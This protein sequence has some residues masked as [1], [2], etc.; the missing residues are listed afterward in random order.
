MRDGRSTG[1]ELVARRGPDTGALLALLLHRGAIVDAEHAWRV[2]HRQ[3]S[4]GSALG[5]AIDDAELA[6][7][8]RG[9]F[10]PA[11]FAGLSAVLVGHARALC[12]AGG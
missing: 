4:V 8:Q 1:A 3:S 11:T 9:A 12:G 2:L 6:G 5:R 10:V 7:L